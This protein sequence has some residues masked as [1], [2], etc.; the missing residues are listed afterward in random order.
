MTH[1]QERA[2]HPRTGAPGTSGQQPPPAS[3]AEPAHPLHEP[4]V[5]SE[6]VHHIPASELFPQGDHDKLTTRLQ[7]S[8]STFVDSPRQAV[9]QADTALDEAITQLT[10][11]L[12]ERRRMLRTVWQGKDTD[13]QTEELRQA[14]RQYRETLERLLTL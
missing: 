13:A 8:L 7:Q 11:A 4:A 14:L 9:E 3:R 6:D 5:S 2:P 10:E 12:A 1:D